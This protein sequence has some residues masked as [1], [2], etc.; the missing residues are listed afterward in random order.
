MPT[1]ALAGGVWSL[2]SGDELQIELR[3]RKPQ[4]LYT[5]VKSRP[6]DD[7]NVKRLELEAAGWEFD[8]RGKTTFRMRKPKPI[9]DALED[10]VWSLLANM[11][12]GEM[13]RGR[14]GRSSG[15]HINV[16]TST[17]TTMAM[18]P[19]QGIGPAWAFRGVGTSTSLR[20]P[21][22][23]I[24]GGT[25]TMVTKSAMIKLA[26][27]LMSGRRSRWYENATV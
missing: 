8:R 22:T 14:K 19:E 9:G 16:G 5:Q 2:V 23:R 25:S 10:Y 17:P 7:A 18:P 26:K 24:S 4:F 1:T 3:R 13:N 6:R 15:A 27:R 11:G 12:F 21:E 20:A